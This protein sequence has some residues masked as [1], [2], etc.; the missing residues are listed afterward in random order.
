MNDGFDLLDELLSEIKPKDKVEG[1][2]LSALK[3]KTLSTS[4]SGV[5]G[6]TYSNAHKKWKAYIKFKGKCKHLGYFDNKEDAIKIRKKAEE[7]LFK[8][9]LDKYDNNKEGEF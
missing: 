2:S 4:K 5:K 6:V 7:I 3:R 9:I 8:P 1:T